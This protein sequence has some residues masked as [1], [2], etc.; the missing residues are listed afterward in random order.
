MDSQVS[1]DHEE[2]PG[3][4]DEL[5]H[6]SSSNAD[7]CNTVGSSVTPVNNRLP[8]ACHGSSVN[9]TR[10]PSDIRSSDP[11]VS[12]GQTYLLIPDFQQPPSLVKLDVLTHCGLNLMS[13]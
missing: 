13:G 1:E 6:T 4:C 8:S 9:I 2:N 10:G 12:A 11:S 7:V 5:L 3:Q